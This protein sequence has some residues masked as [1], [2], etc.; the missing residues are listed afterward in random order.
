MKKLIMF[1]AGLMLLALM[2][3][4]LFFAGAIYDTGNRLS[5]ET[6][7][8]RPNNLSAY[9]IEKPATIDELG[10]SQMF[11]LL[12]RKY[13]TEYFY[14]LPNSDNASSRAAGSGALAIMS[15][16]AAFEKWRS[17]PAKEIVE[18]AKNK[19]L[20]TVRVLN[21]AIKE[22]DFWVVE[23]ETATWTRPNDLTASPEIRRGRMLLQIA[24]EPGFRA[25]IEEF[26][27]VGAVLD[28]GADPATLFNFV[29]IDVFEG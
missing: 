12:V 28:N 17:G 11:Q 20:R 19:A 25:I 4:A 3:G 13:I 18:L 16:N 9:R 24:Y 15:G 6:Y 7:M 2:C 29:V 22:G 26:G 5:V 10:D 14:V 27:G 8:F 21:D 23:Y 1:I